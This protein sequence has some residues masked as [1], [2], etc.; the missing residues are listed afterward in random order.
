MTTAYACL[1][2]PAGKTSPLSSQ[3]VWWRQ[4]SF[5]WSFHH[6]SIFTRCDRAPT[7]SCA[8]LHEALGPCLFL[9]V[10]RLWFQRH[11]SCFSRIWQPPTGYRPARLVW[12]SAS[13]W[14]ADPED[15]G[16][17][18][19]PATAV[20]AESPLLAAA[21]VLECWTQLQA[22]FLDFREL[23]NS[24][25]AQGG[26]AASV[27]R[28]SIQNE[29]SA[30]CPHMLAPLL[31]LPCRPASV[32]RGQHKSNTDTSHPEVSS[33][34][35]EQA[36]LSSWITARTE[37]QNSIIRRTF[38]SLTYTVAASFDVFF[39]MLAKPPLWSVEFMVCLSSSLLSPPISI[40]VS[41]YPAC[42]TVSESLVCSCVH[43]WHKSQSKLTALWAWCFGDLFYFFSP[44]DSPKRLLW[45]YSCN[46]KCLWN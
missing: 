39:K 3:L 28:W 33:V 6:L 18:G 30:I 34:T 15:E 35:F 22:R 42:L 11:D 9:L 20:K 27:S 4:P 19:V 43:C 31:L 40:S 2:L 13:Q 17:A 41:V 16:K 44:H 38:H 36:V 7:N 46:H 24:Q 37:S 23:G 26:I 29:P 5:E 32:L 8:C 21:F 10:G 1:W 25:R 14:K 45:A 12:T